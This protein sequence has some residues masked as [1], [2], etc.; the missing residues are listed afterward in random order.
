MRCFAPLQP[1]SSAHATCLYPS[2]VLGQGWKAFDVEGKGH[3][4]KGDLRRVCLEMGYKVRSR[5]TPTVTCFYPS[6]HVILHLPRTCHV[7][8]PHPPLSCR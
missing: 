3:I 8:I 1:A 4:D 2:P 6:F 7:L 5:D